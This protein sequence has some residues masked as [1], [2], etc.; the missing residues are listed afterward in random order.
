MAH[1]MPFW[2]MLFVLLECLI[3]STNQIPVLFWNTSRF[4]HV[5][6]C[7][8]GVFDHPH[9][10][11]HQCLIATPVLRHMQSYSFATRHCSKS[12]PK[13]SRGDTVW[14]ILPQWFE[15]WKNLELFFF[16]ISWCLIFVGV[17]NVS[18]RT[19]HK[20][21]SL[22]LSR[23]SSV[24][25]GEQQ[26]SL[27]CNAYARLEVLSGVAPVGWRT[28]LACGLCFFWKSVRVRLKVILNLNFVC[29]KRV[30]I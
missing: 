18:S 6:E 22:E 9:W 26:L 15:G 27:L 11:P 17:Q 16:P 5:S 30:I 14:V 20:S 25:Y 19:C 24:G 3:S 21:C 28:V 1:L 23:S 12:S 10:S 4:L 13:P 8:P 2:Q 29:T 7:D